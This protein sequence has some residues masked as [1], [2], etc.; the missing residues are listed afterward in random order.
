V[1]V[2]GMPN[3]PV[4]LLQIGAILL[5]ARLTGKL[6]RRFGQP[7]VVGEMAAG[8]VLGPSVL[9]WLFPAV[10]ARLF[11]AASLGFLYALCQV[12]LVLFMFLVGVDLDPRFL[13]E[14]GHVAI[15]T[16]H[17]SILAP[18]FLGTLLALKLYP[19]F[20]NPAVPFVS[21]ALFLGTAMSVTAFPVLA[22]I[23][24][25]RGL[26]KSPV[27]TVALACAAVDDVS[28][29]CILAGVVLVAR[30]APGANGLPRILA[31]TALFIGASE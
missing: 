17:A 7:Q 28:A 12:G 29:W 15:V 20:S 13:R 5:T 31:G 22:R 6:F 4:L 25:E 16:S 24:H 11:P 2:T 14:R 18:F 23:L 30:A 10:S 3:V 27:G 26:Q 1:P 8:I 9:G 19:E 21:F